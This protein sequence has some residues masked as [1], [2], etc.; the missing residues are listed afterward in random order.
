MILS[1]PILMSETFGGEIQ[2][3]DTLVEVSGSDFNTGNTSLT[4]ITGLT[5]A[6]VANTKYEIEGML[7]G[8]CSDTNGCDFCVT[9]S[10]AG[11]TGSYMAFSPSASTTSGGGVASVGTAINAAVWTTA[12]TDMHTFIRSIVNVGVN[13]GN[14]TIQVKKLTAGTVTVRIGSIMKIRQL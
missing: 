12:T 14:I 3:W 4:N 2:D 7:L 9:F 11:A 1:I 10:A 5:F 6:A 8:Q 13:P